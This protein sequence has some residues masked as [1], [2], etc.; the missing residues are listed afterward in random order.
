MNGIG[1]KP[2]EKI[3]ANRTTQRL[4]RDRYVPAVVGA[5]L[6]LLLGVRVAPAGAPSPGSAVHSITR[7]ELGLGAPGNGAPA[8]FPAETTT[9]PA[10]AAMAYERNPAI[11]AARAEWRASVERYRVATGLPDPRLMITYFPDPI[12]TRLG[13]QDWNAMI[14]QAIPFPGKLGKAGAVVRKDAEMAR[15]RLDRTHRD[16][17]LSLAESFYELFYIDRAR[18]I[19]EANRELLDTL[20]AAG[21]AAYARDR[22]ALADMVRA[23]SRAGQI[24]YDILL[25]EELAQTE[26]ARING[27]LARPPEAPLGPVADAPTPILARSLEEIYVLAETR[28]ESIRHAGLAV[29]KAEAGEALARYENYPNFMAGLFFA[30]IGNPDVPMP[31]PDAGGDAFGVQ[32]GV[33]IPLWFGKNRGR[34]GEARALAEKAVAER[35]S[36]IHEV[37]TQIRTAFFRL[38]NAERLMGLYR[39]DL[40]PQALSALESAETWFREERGAFSDVVETQA[41]AYN[42][43]LA[44]ARA[45]ADYGK[46]FARLERLAGGSLREEGS[47]GDAP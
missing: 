26:R 12:E 6:L 15:L 1:G 31:P 22:A 46:A 2:R 27:L 43:Q 33:S 38:R 4:P 19:A 25:L 17:A 8:D 36:R 42:F 18:T 37:R 34:I 9:L 11:R 29:E 13:P 5:V 20:E 44:L 23:R 45:H 40:L 28:E 10:L 32:F 16:V 3:M 41:V 47:G 14:S 30:G 24:R 21:E 7:A 35:E 39:D